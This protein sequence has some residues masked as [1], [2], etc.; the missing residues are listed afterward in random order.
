MAHARRVEALGQEDAS[1]LHFDDEGGLFLVLHG[2]R[3]GQHHF[4]E[5]A[6]EL[7]LA[8]VEVHGDARLPILTEDFRRL[9]SLEGEVAHIDALQGELRVVVLLGGAG[10]SLLSHFRTFLCFVCSEDHADS[11]ASSLPARSSA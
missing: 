3:N 8:G 10:S 1:L 4:V 6:L 2:H 7:L 9:G 11:S 5:V